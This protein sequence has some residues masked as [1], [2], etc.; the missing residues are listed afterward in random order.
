MLWPRLARAEYA[1]GLSSSE[2]EREKL[3]TVAQTAEAWGT[4]VHYPR[5]LI[6]ERRIRFVRIGRHVRI[7]ESVVDDWIERGTVEPVDGRPR[8]RTLR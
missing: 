3:L 4:S 2:W 6:Q 5:R 7:P 1:A 8:G